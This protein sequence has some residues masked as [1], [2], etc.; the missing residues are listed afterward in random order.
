MGF[1]HKG[2]CWAFSEEDKDQIQHYLEEHGRRNP[3][4]ASALKELVTYL[5][6]DNDLYQSVVSEA[7]S[8]GL[9]VADIRRL[10]LKDRYDRQRA[11]WELRKRDG[12]P[13]S[14]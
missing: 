5:H 2:Y 14:P 13:A 1:T 10:S 8:T 7:N 4:Y 6:E 9:A 3:K 12:V 11:E